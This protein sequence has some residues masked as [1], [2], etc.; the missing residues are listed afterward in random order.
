MPPAVP[1]V[2]RLTFALGVLLA[3]TATGTLAQSTDRTQA[4]N[5]ANEGIAKSLTDQIGAGRGDLLTPNSSAYILARDPFRAIRRESGVTRWLD[6]ARS[7]R[8]AVRSLASGTL[9]LRFQ[10]RVVLGALVRFQ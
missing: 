10:R 5:P 1:R 2:L 4:P 3:T 6:A 9:L 8:G 7:A